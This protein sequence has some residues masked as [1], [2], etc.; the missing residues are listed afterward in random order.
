LPLWSGIFVTVRRS[1]HFAT[2]RGGFHASLSLSSYTSRARLGAR[3]VRIKKSCADSAQPNEGANEFQI[4]SG[5]AS[6]RRLIS[7]VLDKCFAWKFSSAEVEMTLPLDHSTNSCLAPVPCIRRSDRLTWLRRNWPVATITA[8][9]LITL[10]W[11][12]ALMCFA[13]MFVHRI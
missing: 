6:A 1:F 10:V 7:Y 9:V 12:G 8:G 3:S 2:L 5:S 11:M 13:L 4:R